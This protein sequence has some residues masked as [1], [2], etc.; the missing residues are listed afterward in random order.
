MLEFKWIHVT[1]EGRRNV[2]YDISF[3]SQEFSK[4]S[5]NTDD[6]KYIFAEDLIHTAQTSTRA[7]Y[8]GCGTWNVK[9]KASKAWA[10]II[11]KNKMKSKEEEDE[12]DS[13]RAMDPGCS[14]NV[15]CCV[16]ITTI[17][18]AD[19]DIPKFVHPHNHSSIRHIGKCGI[20]PYIPVIAMPWGRRVLQTELISHYDRLSEIVLGNDWVDKA[21]AKTHF[22]LSFRHHWIVD[23]PPFYSG[24][25]YIRN[26]QD[27]VVGA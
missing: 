1:I 26:F 20:R 2:R 22:F 13:G 16:I 17:R 10:L 8:R 19:D 21:C 6:L 27:S 11:N 12:W 18:W 5:S 7:R 4:V 24:T 3:D 9:H 23:S 14:S 25:A 15:D